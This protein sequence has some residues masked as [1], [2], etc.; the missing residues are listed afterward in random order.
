MYRY[1]LTGVIALIKVELT[2]DSI[3]CIAAGHV[4]LLCWVEM[5]LGGV[6]FVYPIEYTRISYVL[7]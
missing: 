5:R 6:A 1:R 3:C 4:I 2:T 7:D